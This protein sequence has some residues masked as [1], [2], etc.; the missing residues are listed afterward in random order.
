MENWNQS[1][2]RNMFENQ[3]EKQEKEGADESSVEARAFLV[4]KLGGAVDGMENEQEVVLD[5]GTIVSMDLRLR[6]YKYGDSAARSALGKIRVQYEAPDDRTWER[7]W[8]DLSSGE[9]ED[10]LERAIRS[11]KT[12]E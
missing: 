2:Y 7:S 6:P 12:A 1:R 8:A 10:L 9:R 3:A 5:D 4:E 11:C